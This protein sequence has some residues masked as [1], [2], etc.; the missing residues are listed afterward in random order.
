MNVVMFAEK[1]IIFIFIWNSG[2]IKSWWY[3]D[4]NEGQKYFICMIT[5]CWW[6]RQT[7]LCP[8]S[9]LK[10][11]PCSYK[12]ISLVLIKT[13]S[14]VLIKSISSVLIKNISLVL[15]KVFPWS[16]SKVFPWSSSKVFPWSSSKYFLDLHQKCFLGLHQKYFLGAHLHDYITL[17]RGQ[18]KEAFLI[19]FHWYSIDYIPLTWAGRGHHSLTMVN[20]GLV[21]INNICL[22]FSPVCVFKCALK[23]FGSEHAKTHCTGCICLTFLIILN[24]PDWAGLA[25]SN[26]G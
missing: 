24:W 11:F 23:A 3:S 8:W 19:I 21:M 2:Q 16:S 4:H 13:I 9:L 25:Q 15:I 14:L 17:V 26:I 12:S 10:V 6:G 1:F 20:N 5:L 7:K 22:L 18:T